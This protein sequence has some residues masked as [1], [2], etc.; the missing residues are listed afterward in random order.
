[1]LL[2]PQKSLD[3]KKGAPVQSLQEDLLFHFLPFLYV[4]EP[5]KRYMSAWKIFGYLPKFSRYLVLGPYIPTPISSAILE[6]SVY[7]LMVFLFSLQVMF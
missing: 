6:P 1:M 5:M 3:P 7:R 2:I 4:P